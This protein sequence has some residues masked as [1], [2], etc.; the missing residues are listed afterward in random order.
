MNPRLVIRSLLVAGVAALILATHVY[1]HAHGRVGLFVQVLNHPANVAGVAL[2]AAA[3][4]VLT[5][6]PKPKAEKPRDARPARSR[7]PAR[8]RR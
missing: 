6:K 5:H 4:L 2:F 3:L 7:V 8:G 1:R